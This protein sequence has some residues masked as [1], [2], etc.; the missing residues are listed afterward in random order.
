MTEQQAPPGTTRNLPP[1][2]A[3]GTAPSSPP[4][5]P[6]MTAHARII[7]LRRVMRRNRRKSQAS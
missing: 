7:Q 6:R 5:P 3:N 4:A 2:S 1:P